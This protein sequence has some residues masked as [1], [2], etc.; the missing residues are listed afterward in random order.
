[1]NTRLIY[2]FVFCLS[3]P[4]GLAASASG[5]S[6]EDAY[7]RVMPPG[8]TATAA[9][10]S[11][12]NNHDKA[13]SIIGGSSAMAA[14]LEIHQQLMS[15][16]MMKM[17]PVTAVTVAAGETL[18]LQPGGFHLMLLG[19]ETALVVGE[20]HDMSLQTEDCGAIEITAEVRSLF[21]KAAA[22][23]KAHD[24]SMH[25]HSG[26]NMHN[27]HKDGKPKDGMHK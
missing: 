15:D 4:F 11:V 10:L 14:K 27:M 20:A 8:R 9:Y 16:G 19:V 18:V 6:V 26:H 7:M 25:D 12:T 2:C 23:E 21:K 5:F 22:A 24:H 3:M 13:C 1:M 17:R